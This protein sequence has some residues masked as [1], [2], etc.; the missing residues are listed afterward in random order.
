M[1]GPISCKRCLT[2]NH[3]LVPIPSDEGKVA[4]ETGVYSG[5]PASRGAASL[6]RFPN[7]CYNSKSISI[8]R[9]SFNAFGGV[10]LVLVSPFFFCCKLATSLCICSAVRYAG[11]S[12]PS[13]NCFGIG[14]LCHWICVLLLLTLCLLVLFGT[15]FRVKSH[16]M[17]CAFK[18]ADS[19]AS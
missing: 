15:L 12:G 19:G 14:T 17:C 7:P 1:G 3:C 8:F 11:P 9:P 4:G 5:L 13:W 18:C 16:H 6:T 2:W 10:C